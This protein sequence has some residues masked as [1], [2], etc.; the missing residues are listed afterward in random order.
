MSFFNI[1][2][3]YHC[4]YMVYLIRYM[5]YNSQL[6]IKSQSMIF[7]SLYIKHLSMESIIKFITKKQTLKQRFCWFFRTLGECGKFKV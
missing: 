3:F 7:Y 1:K 2:L 4:I 5:F 6:C